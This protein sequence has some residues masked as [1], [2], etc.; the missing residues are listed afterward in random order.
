MI[1]FGF[2]DS[3]ENNNKNNGKLHSKAQFYLRY[4]PFCHSLSVSWRRYLPSKYQ[5]KLHVSQPV[6]QVEGP[7]SLLFIYLGPEPAI[8][9]RVHGGENSLG[10]SIPTTEAWCSEFMAAQDWSRQDSTM[11]GWGRNHE[12][13]PI[14]GEC[15]QLMHCGRSVPFFSPTAR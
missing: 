2:L 7:L 6:N 15:R 10:I 11:D 14:P 1:C 12:G 9:T 5:C 3:Y 13:P 8:H 4:K